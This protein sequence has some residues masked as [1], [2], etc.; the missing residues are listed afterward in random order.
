MRQSEFAMAM[1]PS[2]S[3]NLRTAYISLPWNGRRG[4]C[5]PG[6]M[7]SYLPRWQEHRATLQSH[8]AG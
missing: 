4:L 6:E 8:S 5:A 7:R 2:E 3:N 1:D